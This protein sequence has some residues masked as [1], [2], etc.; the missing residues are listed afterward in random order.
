MP[1]ARRSEPA[2]PTNVRLRAVGGCGTPWTPRSSLA[3]P[4]AGLHRPQSIDP[5]DLVAIMSAEGSI[6]TH[7]Q[8]C[9]ST[10]D[11]LRAAL[12][13]SSTARRSVFFDVPEQLAGQARNIRYCRRDA[14]S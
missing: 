9:A 13:T 14:R 5:E 11:C 2:L 7:A 3:Y 12:A 4:F 8:V 10:S 6:Q 1:P